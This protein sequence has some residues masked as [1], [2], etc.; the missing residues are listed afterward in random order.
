MATVIISRGEGQLGNRLFQFATFHAAAL[1][2]GFRVWNPAFGD[3]AS[4][5]P[6]LA[7]DVFCRPDCGRP[8]NADRRLACWLAE[9]LTAR[10]WRGVVRL[11]GGEVLDISGSHDACEKEYDLGSGDFAARLAGRR[12]LIAKGW[13]FRAR[14][15][16]WKWRDRVREVFRP[17][18]DVMDRASRRVAEARG[19]AEVLIGVHVRRGDYAEWLG[20]RHFYDWE[21]Y[22][23]WMGQAVALHPGKRVAFLV[24]SNENTDR[25]PVVEGARATPG[26]GGVAEDLYALAGCD[27][28]MGPPS[29]FT[30]WA[31]YWGGVRLHMLERAGEPLWA[32]GFV[33]HREV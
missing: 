20:G 31:S 28:L 7:A 29:T 26:P 14:E 27:L 25:L 6:A 5:F 16:L 13:K 17:N 33:M 11:A 12:F 10:G 2:S 8:W 9:G 24:C 3:Y 15:A 18:I 4:Y 21:D 1:E 32:G 30:L 19:D 23:R 22:A